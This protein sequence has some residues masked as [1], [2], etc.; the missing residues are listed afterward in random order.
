MAEPLSVAASVVGLIA[1][2]DRVIR[3]SQYCIDTI[4]DAPS[5]VRMI[6]G[7]TISLR[8]VFE[9]LTDTGSGPATRLLGVDDPIEAC[10]RCLTALEALLP[11]R[12]GSVRHIAIADLAWPFKAP[13]A[14]KIL[15]EISQH[16]A[17]LLLAISRD[18]L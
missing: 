17:T 16:K 9:S 12:H 2:A 13:K 5:D 15:A 6:L 4:K 3:V 11:Q 1:L 14:R 10:R 18:M 7:E 8:A